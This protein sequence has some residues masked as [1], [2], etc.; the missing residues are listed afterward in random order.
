MHLAG[1]LADRPNHAEI[2]D[3]RTACSSVPLKE[4]DPPAPLCQNVGVRQSKD[5]S[6]NNGN[7]RSPG[8]TFQDN[9]AHLCGW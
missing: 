7:I 5:A 1:R 2:A 4:N 8:H 6:T 9:P 3:R